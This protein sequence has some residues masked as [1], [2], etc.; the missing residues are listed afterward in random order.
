MGLRQFVVNKIIKILPVTRFYR[1][2]TRLYALSGVD[3]HKSARIVSLEVHG[4]LKLSIGVDTYIGH[5]VLITGGDCTIEIGDFCDIGHRVCIFGGT[6]EMNMDEGHTAGK[7]YSK[8]IRIGDGAWIGSNTTILSGVT[9]GEKVVVAAGS[10]VSK[11]IP[12]YT[13]VS[14]VGKTRKA[15]LPKKG[16]F[17]L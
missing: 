1:L 7:G 15:P 12:S 14:T 8:N 3:V 5:D 11:N 17:Q 6:H 4:N 16:S 9:I 13:F 2:K 10:V